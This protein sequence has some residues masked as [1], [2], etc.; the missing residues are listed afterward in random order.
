V[1]A[2]LLAR[3]LSV[4]AGDRALVDNGRHADALVE[5]IDPFR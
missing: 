3:K 2:R 4:R 1:Q 5:S